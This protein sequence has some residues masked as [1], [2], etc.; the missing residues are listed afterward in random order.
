MNGLRRR[1]TYIQW[2]NAQPQKEQDNAICNNMDGT[3][4]YY[5]M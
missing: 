1:G 2:N 3:R 4:N 5:T